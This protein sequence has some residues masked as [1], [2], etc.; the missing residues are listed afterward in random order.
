MTLVVACGSRTGSTVTV[1]EAGYPDGHSEPLVSSEE[2]GTKSGRDSTPETYQKLALTEVMLPVRPRIECNQVS[3]TEARTATTASAL[4]INCV[5]FGAAGT[6]AAPEDGKFEWAFEPGSSRI[7][8]TLTVPDANG[9]SATFTFSAPADGRYD[10]FKESAYALLHAA[11][12]GRYKIS[13]AGSSYGFKVNQVGAKLGGQRCTTPIS[14]LVNLV[15]AQGWSVVNNPNTVSVPPQEGEPAR[16]SNVV[17][18]AQGGFSTGEVGGNFILLL[19]GTLRHTGTG[20]RIMVI[21]G[22]YVSAAKAQKVIIA[23]PAA[24]IRTAKET[25]ILRFRSDLGFC[26][27]EPI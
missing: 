4:V 23:G 9:S 3:L 14:D 15:Q 26:S 20:G 25:P 21:D 24:V 22:S 1:I 5:A 6:V 16:T 8:P 7:V 2:L 18:G 11:D 17:I 12:V 27:R 10:L 13:Y 19:G